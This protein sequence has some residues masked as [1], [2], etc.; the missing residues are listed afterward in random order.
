MTITS[1]AEQDF[2]TST[3]SGGVWIGLMKD[4]G[5]PV[6]KD[7]F[8]WVTGEPTTYQNWANGQPNGG[9]N[10]VRLR[11]DASWGDTGCDMTLPAICERE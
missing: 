4:P 6:A 11:A 10:C 1:Q 8:R 3:G 7:S 9:G 2:I 5:A